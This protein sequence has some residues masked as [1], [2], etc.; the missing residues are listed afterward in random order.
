MSRLSKLIEEFYKAGKAEIKKN[1]DVPKQKPIDDNKCCEDELNNDQKSVV[2]EAN[3]GITKDYLKNL[4]QAKYP[5]V[6]FTNAEFVGDANKNNG[7]MSVYL[8]NGDEIEFEAYTRGGVLDMISE[9]VIKHILNK[10]PPLAQKYFDVDSLME[11]AMKL[12]LEDLKNLDIDDMDNYTSL[13]EDGDN[14]IFVKE[15]F[16]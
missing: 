6:D 12:N 5:D 13:F 8:N 10:M 16:Y 4:I 1:F 3:E 7:N 14:V 9:V 2:W 11:R 15:T